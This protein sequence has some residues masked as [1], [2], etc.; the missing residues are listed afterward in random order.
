M[1]IIRTKK[2][3]ISSTE[4]SLNFLK[5]YEKHNSL[6]STSSVKFHIITLK[7]IT[8]EKVFENFIIFRKTSTPNSNGQI[9]SL[10]CLLCANLLKNYFSSRVIGHHFARCW[11]PV[12]LLVIKQFSTMTDRKRYQ[13]Y[14]KIDN[15]ERKNRQIQNYSWGIQ[16]PSLR[17]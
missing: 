1:L 10:I 9:F 6:F 15:V 13:F 4:V 5:L 16:Q 14:L 3:K 7:S 11:N 12:T 8:F 17:N 2:V